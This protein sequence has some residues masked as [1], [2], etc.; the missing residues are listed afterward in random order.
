MFS[1]GLLYSFSDFLSKTVSCSPFLPLRTDTPMGKNGFSPLESESSLMSGFCRQLRFLVW[2][3]RGCAYLHPL[4]LSPC[5]V[6][7]HDGGGSSGSRSTLTSP[8]QCL[9]PTAMAW[10]PLTTAPP[11]RRAARSAKQTLGRARTSWT[12]WRA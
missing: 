4:Y 6:R 3:Q 12:G 1:K 10:P 8:F 9:G 5:Q 11:E 7:R 2:S